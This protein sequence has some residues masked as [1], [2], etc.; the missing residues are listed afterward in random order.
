MSSFTESGKKRPPTFFHREA[1]I[2]SN[3]LPRLRLS[4]DH[5][6]KSS[7]RHNL[8]FLD[9]FVWF[10]HHS[11]ELPN[12]SWKIWTRLGDHMVVVGSVDISDP[13]PSDCGVDVEQESR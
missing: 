13:V 9:C 4:F 3:T 6:H 12:N 1:L 2:R 8:T 10:A 11:G 7:T 5:E